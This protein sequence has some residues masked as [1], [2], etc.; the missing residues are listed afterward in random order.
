MKQDILVA[1]GSGTVHSSPPPYLLQA[2]TLYTQM[3]PIPDVS[4]AQSTLGISLA[5]ADIYPSQIVLATPDI[6]PAPSTLE[7]LTVPTY[8]C[9][10]RAVGTVWVH[11]IGTPPTTLALLSALLDLLCR[12]LRAKAGSHTSEYIRSCSNQLHIWQMHT[13]NMPMMHRCRMATKKG[14]LRHTGGSLATKTRRYVLCIYTLSYLKLCSVL[15]PGKDWRSRMLLH[16]Y[17]WSIPLMFSNRC[18]LI[19]SGDHTMT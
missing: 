1:S 18:A 3:A 14:N 9:P 12:R 6:S 11:R 17:N 10:S 8:I 15:H 4:P 16:A 2:A 7:T 13:E 5:P 19:S